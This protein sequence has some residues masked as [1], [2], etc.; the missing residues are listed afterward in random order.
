[1]QKIALFSWFSSIFFAAACFAGNLHPQ[2]EANNERVRSVDAARIQ[3]VRAYESEG[4][5]VVQGANDATDARSRLEGVRHRWVS[6][7]GVCAEE[8]TGAPRSCHDGAWPQL[9]LAQEAWARL[10]EHAQETSVDT[11]AFRQAA[12]ALQRAYCAAETAI[13]S[14]VSVPPDLHAACV[15]RP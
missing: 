13:P 11:T 1:M 5:A 10:L 3:L 4:L 2:I 7:W 12:D 9:L 6:L 8:T 14:G 15:T